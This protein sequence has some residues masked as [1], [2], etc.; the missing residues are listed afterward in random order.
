MG[1]IYGIP[2]DEYE[3]EF[4]LVKPLP[5]GDF[6]WK[7]NLENY[8]VNV[9]DGLSIVHNIRIAHKQKKKNK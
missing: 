3:Y 1:R 5:D 6:E 7:M 2:E 4:M 8:P 9:P